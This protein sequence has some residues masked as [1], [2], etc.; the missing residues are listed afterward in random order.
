[1]PDILV[2]FQ[3]VLGIIIIISV[4]TAAAIVVVIYLKGSPTSRG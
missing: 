4:D 2:I 3:Q 1:M